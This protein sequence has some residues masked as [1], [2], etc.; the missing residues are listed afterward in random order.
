LEVKDVV[1]VEPT[2]FGDSRGFF[3]ETFKKSEFAKEGINFSPVQENLSRSSKGVLRGL[4]YQSD[5]FAQGKLVRAMRGRIFD[6]AVDIR[7]TSPSFA[8]WVGVELSDTNKNALLVPRGFAHGFVALEDGTE[9]DYLVDNEYSK[10]HEQGVIW[11]DTRIAVRWPVDGPI[12]SE[13]DSAWPRL[14]EASL[15]P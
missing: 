8:K 2:Q 5:P 14:E 7:K 11:N 4:H 1:L 9:V 10:N 15:F 6:V 3:M 12:L 13:R